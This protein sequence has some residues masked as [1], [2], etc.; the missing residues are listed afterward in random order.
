M[1]DPQQMAMS[2]V[3][4]IT[5]FTMWQV[6]CCNAMPG[7]FP[8]FICLHLTIIHIIMQS[9]SSSKTQRFPST[10]GLG[11]S[12]PESLHPVSHIHQ[13]CKANSASHLTCMDLKKLLIFVARSLCFPSICSI[14]GS[15]SLCRP[16]TLLVCTTACIP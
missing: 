3:Q 12:R 8:L 9:C 13:N 14:P 4:S 7:R 1:A 10:T 16:S 6:W 5:S 11:A 2:I 15:C